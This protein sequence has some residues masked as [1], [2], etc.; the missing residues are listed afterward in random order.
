MA[1]QQSTVRGPPG[2][3]R[4]GVG[5]SCCVLSA[6]LQSR[7]RPSGLKAQLHCPPMGQVLN[8][9][10]PASSPIPLGMTESTHFTGLL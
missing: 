9:C 8:P 7:V 3:G 6:S 10:V 5:G 4:W 2:N 1:F